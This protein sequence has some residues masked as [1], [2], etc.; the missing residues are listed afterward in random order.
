MGAPY[1]QELRD[2]VLAAYD[3][4]MLGVIAD[5]LGASLA[6][7]LF[8]F[9][10]AQLAIGGFLDS[11][12]GVI[13]LFLVIDCELTD[14]LAAEVC[15]LGTEGLLFSFDIRFNCPVF[16]WFEVFYFQFALNNQA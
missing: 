7:F 6:L 1:H 2:R 8:D 10:N 14:L 12:P 4:G 15:Q 5:P 3:R 13:G 16:L 9:G 11:S